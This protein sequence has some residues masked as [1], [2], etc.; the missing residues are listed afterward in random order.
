MITYGANV[1]AHLI[2][3]NANES[4]ETAL[5]HV[6]YGIDKNIPLELAQQYAITFRM[7]HLGFSHCRITLQFLEWFHQK[8]INANA[9]KVVEVGV[10]SGFFSY[11]L[12]LYLKSKK[13]DIE[14]IATDQQSDK[15]TYT[16]RPSSHFTTSYPFLKDIPE[17][18][19]DELMD[20]VD[21]IA[22]YGDE[23]TVVAMVYPPPTDLCTRVLQ[24][25]EQK[26]CAG[27][28]FIGTPWFEVALNADPE[29]YKNFRLGSEDEYSETA[30]R[31]ERFDKY[32][33]VGAPYTF[34]TPEE[35]LFKTLN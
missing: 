17:L 28:L 6:L 24:E 33:P 2:K 19:L 11:C 7:I 5:K 35:V 15:M 4:P 18:K 14:V 29:F 12:R 27:L 10:G 30:D 8:L 23:K 9:T 21:A 32:E 25:T 34:I 31:I 20:G 3:E 22:K 16:D 13:S 1:V 26:K